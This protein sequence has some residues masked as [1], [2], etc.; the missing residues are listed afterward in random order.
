M[1]HWKDVARLN[2]SDVKISTKLES[3]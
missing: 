1:C 2:L 3:H